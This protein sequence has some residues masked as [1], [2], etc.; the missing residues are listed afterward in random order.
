MKYLHYMPVSSPLYN[1]M[2]IDM[3]NNNECFDSYEHEFYLIN[4]QSLKYNYNNVSFIPNYNAN[5]LQKDSVNYDYIF[6]HGWNFS[7]Y[8]QIFLRKRLLNKIIWCVW[9]HDLYRYKNI[10]LKGHFSDIIKSIIKYLLR[11]IQTKKIKQIFGVCY[12]FPYDKVEIK[13]RYGDNLRIFEAPY[14]LGYDFSLVN[15]V[16]SHK[17]L[18]TNSI[19]IMI[20]HCAFPFLQ[21]Y[22]LL[23]E[24]RRFENKEITIC[25]PLGYGD[26]EYKQ[27]LIEYL[28]EYPI[29]IEL[30]D[31]YLTPENY[32]KLLSS[33]D[34]AIFDYKHQAALANIYLLLY[35]EKKIYLNFDGVIAKGF[36]EI[37]IQVFNTED[38]KEISFNS[39]TDMNFDISKGVNWSYNILNQETIINKWK[40]VF[41]FC[42]KV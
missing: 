21:H 14:G 27:N 23:E 32:L 15:N 9:G 16:K 35:F 3:I 6:I 33:I 28:K 8:E 36:R 17:R 19:R 39:L 2:I 29:R 4:K 42:K 18:I 13:N 37:G 22:K 25:L 20:G 7:F 5:K 26:E 34:I 12:G 11:Y 31:E 30:Y 10:S 38:L 1:N 40:Y 24:L 41:E